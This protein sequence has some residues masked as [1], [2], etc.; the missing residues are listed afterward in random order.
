ML[1]NILIVLE[2]AV[3]VEKVE[4]RCGQGEEVISVWKKMDIVLERQ[5][6]DIKGKF[7]FKCEEDFESI[8]IIE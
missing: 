3:M 7:G 8:K 6:I 1:M 5:V 2:S 4:N